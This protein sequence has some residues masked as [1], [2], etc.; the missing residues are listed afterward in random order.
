VGDRVRHPLHLVKYHARTLLLN[1]DQ[2]AAVYTAL[3]DAGGTFRGVR[4][5]AVPID[6]AGPVP[7]MASVNAARKLW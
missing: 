5:T 2:H 3:R 4:E 6:E 7:P 1:L